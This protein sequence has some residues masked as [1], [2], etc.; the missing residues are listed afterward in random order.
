MFSFKQGGF[1]PLSTFNIIILFL[2]K[3]KVAILHE[4]LIKL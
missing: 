1:S 4:M 2:E 3:M